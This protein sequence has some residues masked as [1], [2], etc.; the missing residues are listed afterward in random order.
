M[1]SLQNTKKGANFSPTVRDQGLKNAFGFMW[2]KSPKHQPGALPLDPAG[3][4]TP[5]PHYRLVLSTRHG[6]QPPYTLQ[7]GY[8]AVWSSSS[9][10]SLLHHLPLT[11]LQAPG[12]LHLSL[13]LQISALWSLRRHKGSQKAKC[14]TSVQSYISYAIKITPDL[15]GRF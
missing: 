3:A 9:F 7:S 5:F 2:T 15:Q 11:C 8:V 12:Q 4:P 1:N 6:F 13:S 10:S 14:C